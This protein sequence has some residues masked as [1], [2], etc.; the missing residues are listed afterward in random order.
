MV[1]RVGSQKKRRL[2]KRRDALKWLAA[3]GA[4]AFV[5]RSLP[6]R[7]QSKTARIGVLIPL[8]G[9]VDA[10]A[11]QMQIGIETAVTEINVTGG[12]LGRSIAVEY[13]DS[14][15]APAVL[16]DRR[17]GLIDDWEAIAI[18]GP[19][20][21][22]GRKYAARFLADRK[23]PLVNASNSRRRLLFARLVFYRLDNRV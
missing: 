14:E 12:V 7:A 20:V 23:I 9:D 21:S 5:G 3:S 15:I 6:I 13:R 1:E 4:T 18:V 11:R 22:A 19:F 8:S 16:L 10:Y 17:K 2:K